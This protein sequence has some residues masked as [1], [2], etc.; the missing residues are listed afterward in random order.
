MRCG[1]CGSERL[2]PLGQ[3]R[4]E[5]RYQGSLQLLFKRPGV[6]RPRPTFD[7]GF[8]RAC[9][10]CGALFPFLAEESRRRLAATAQDLTDVEDWIPYQ[11]GHN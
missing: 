10:D 1:V 4:S 9:L 2:S 11:G 3:L 8:A 5:Q 6:F 7:A